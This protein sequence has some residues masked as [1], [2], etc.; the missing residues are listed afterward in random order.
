M[1]FPV[2]VTGVRSYAAVDPSGRMTRETLLKA[3]EEFK[4]QSLDLRDMCSA[5]RVVKQEAVDIAQQNQRELLSSDTLKQK[6]DTLLSKIKAYCVRVGTVQG[7][8]ASLHDDIQQFLKMKEPEE[9]SSTSVKD[10]P[11]ASVETPRIVRQEVRE[12]TCTTSSPEDGTPISAEV[13]SETEIVIESSPDSQQ[14][15]CENNAEDSTP[16]SEIT[17]YLHENGVD[18]SDCFNAESL[19]ARY[20]DVKSGAYR[21]VQKQKETDAAARRRELEAKEERQRQRQESSRSSTNTQQ[22]QSSSQHSSQNMN[23]GGSPSGGLM[24]DPYPGAERRMCDPMKYVWEVKREICAG[25]SVNPEQMDIWVG[26][27]KLEDHRRIHE[28][29]QVQY[30]PM[31]FRV[32]GDQGFQQKTLR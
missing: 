15:E 1:C 32:K 28:Y 18:F 25:K 14:K 9:S 17:Q 16:V 3:A 19:R 23:Y 29:P 20:R 13:I 7:E 4:G 5:A 24:A 2:L 8:A 12:F 21:P 22:N 26:G 10:K 30:S 11:A 6:W 31:E 27:T